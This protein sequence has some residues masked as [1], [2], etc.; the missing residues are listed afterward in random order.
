M[1]SLP[2][3]LKWPLRVNKVRTKVLYSVG[4]VSCLSNRC[5]TSLLSPSTSVVI[6]A[7]SGQVSTPAS[8]SVLSNRSRYATK[9]IDLCSIFLNRY[10]VFL[11][12]L[13]LS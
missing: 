12:L 8:K 13:G 6:L 2:R 5:L 7:L 9:L 11:I 3:S 10:P 1:V 4:S